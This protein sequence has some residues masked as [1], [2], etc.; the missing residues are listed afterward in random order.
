MGVKQIV[1]VTD[2]LT[3][4]TLS[5]QPEPTVITYNGKKHELY[6]SPESAARFEKFLEGDSP[7]VGGTS[8]STDSNPHGYDLKKVRAWAIAKGLKNGA[9]K[10]KTM[11]ETTPVLSKHIYE[12]FHDEQGDQD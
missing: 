9:K 1:Q 4:K 5:E 10:D 6:L 2:D 11:T 7:I 8:S 12:A 3:G